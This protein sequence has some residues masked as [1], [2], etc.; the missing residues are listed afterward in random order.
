MAW[1]VGCAQE[2]MNS[3]MSLQPENAVEE[4]EEDEVLQAQQENPR[5]SLYKDS[6]YSTLY[7]A[8]LGELLLAADTS[9]HWEVQGGR[10]HM[11]EEEL[12]F[13]KELR[14]MQRTILFLEKTKYDIFVTF[15]RGGQGQE[16]NHIELDFSGI[17]QASLKTELEIDKLS[18]LP[19]EVMKIHAKIDSLEHFTSR[20]EIKRLQKV[21]CHSL[22]DILPEA[23]QN[24]LATISEVCDR[25]YEEVLVEGKDYLLEQKAS[26]VEGE[27][28][29]KHPG[30]YAIYFYGYDTQGQL[31]SKSFR[32][33]VLEGVKISHR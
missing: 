26:S 29:F 4:V 11:Y 15:N 33:I 1:M 7:H 20:W 25:S 27:I 9:I 5:L 10:Y 16:T 6:V 12:S 21:K 3:T 28:I 31:L 18:P 32:K 17:S 22:E 13:F 2:E 24:E 30:T 14:P 23:M 8:D 19:G